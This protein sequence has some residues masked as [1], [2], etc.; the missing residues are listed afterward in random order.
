MPIDRSSTYFFYRRIAPSVIK[1]IAG[2]SPEYSASLVLVRGAMGGYYVAVK[3]EEAAKTLADANGWDGYVR[4]DKISSDVWHDFKRSKAVCLQTLREL[5]DF[6]K[7]HSKA[8][9]DR[10]ADWVT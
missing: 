8:D 7:G 2:A 4:G 10:L 3:S 1:G 6:M 5:E 9:L